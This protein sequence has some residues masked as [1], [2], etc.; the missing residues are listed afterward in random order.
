MHAVFKGNHWKALSLAQQFLLVGGLVSLVATIIVG[1][2]LTSLIEDAVTRNSGAATALYVD[3]VIAPLLPDMQNSTALSDSVKQ[4]LD[5][6]LGQGALG[7]RL[8]SFKLWRADGTILYSNNRQQ[9]GQKLPISDG[10]QTALTGKM[11]AEYDDVDDVGSE[12]ERESGIPLLEVYNP[13]LQP[14]SGDVVAVL[15]FYEIATD[16]QHSL[17]H[18]RLQSWIAVV[19][20]TMTFF[21]ILSALVFKGS[22]MIDSQREALKKRI[23]DL[24]NLL[25]QNGELSSKLQRAS[26]RTT[27]LNERYL[28]RLGAE[29]HDGPAQLVALAAL[30]VDSDVISNPR[31]SRKVRDGELTSIRS[32]L[33]DAMQE[34][35]AICS[36]LVLPQI[37]GADLG[38]I[39]ERALKAHLQ[40][41]GT[42]VRLSLSPTSPPL[43]LSAKICVFRFV[44]EA[45]NNGFRHGGGVG[46]YVVQTFDGQN[47]SITVGDSGPGFD[48][49]D[50][51]PSSLGLSGLHE[52]VESLGGHFDLKT[53]NQGTVLRM[54]LNLNEMEPA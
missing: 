36:G 18:A 1:A 43:S 40:R 34:I 13:V 20:F 35:R 49:A 42:T 37:E 45:L 17:N 15:E 19:A 44:Q 23:Q 31:T 41:T 21:A 16:F 27:A 9:I 53:S 47:V 12:S 6:T 29:L 32:S 30:K 28:R 11:V 51:K 52:R 14:W 5:E 2:F 3:S 33:D 8:M 22:R 26:Q 48:P 10:L 39:I 4:A 24:S 38:E 54:S 50:I 25:T 7:K 46:Q